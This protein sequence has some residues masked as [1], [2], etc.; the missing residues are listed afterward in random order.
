MN[1]SILLGRL[2]KAPEIRMSSANN[3][4]LIANFTLAVNRKYVKPG[5]ERQADFINIVAY[6]KLA[7]FANKYLRQGLQICVCGRIQTRNYDDKN[8]IKRYVT[9]VIAE[10]IVFADSFKKED[11]RILN[12][13]KPVNTQQ[14]TDTNTNEDIFPS[15]DDLPF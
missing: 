2:T 5:E 4:M 12:S 8:G 11:D 10:E 1:K 14:N 3:D 7:D 9:E 15:E 6:S 13:D